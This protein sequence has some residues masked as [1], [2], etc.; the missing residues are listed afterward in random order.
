MILNLKNVV[1]WMVYDT[2]VMCSVWRVA[3][4]RTFSGTDPL[5]PSTINL[6]KATSR[7][8]GGGGVGSLSEFEGG[9]ELLLLVAVFMGN[10]NVMVK[11]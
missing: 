9:G 7:M 3:L 10:V 2:S 5:S 8:L 4:I 1:L 6:S 11:V